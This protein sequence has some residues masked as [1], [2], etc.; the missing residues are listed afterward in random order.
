MP[1]C[2]KRVAA[3]RAGQPIAL[4]AGRHERRGGRGPV[5]GISWPWPVARING[6]RTS[7]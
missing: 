4:A 2:I 7:A 6:R 5:T 3:S 1:G